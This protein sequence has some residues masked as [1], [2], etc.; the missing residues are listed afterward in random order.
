[1]RIVEC[2]EHGERFVLPTREQEFLSGKYHEAV[3]KC[4]SHHELNPN[5]RFEEV[6]E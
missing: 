6:Q 5:C 1:M 2:K 4:H 3:E